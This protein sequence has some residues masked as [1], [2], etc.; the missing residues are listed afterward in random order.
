MKRK[1]SV[2]KKIED[3]KASAALKEVSAVEGCI[4]VELS[5]DKNFLI[6][7]ARDDAYTDVM[8]L[9]VNVFARLC[10]DAKLSFDSFIM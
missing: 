5:E 9:A 3:E 4:S 10:D 8:N 7:E 1:Y 6:V 2:S